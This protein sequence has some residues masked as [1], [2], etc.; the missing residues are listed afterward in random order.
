MAVNPLAHLDRTGDPEQQH[1][2]ARHQPFAYAR[3]LHWAEALPPPEAAVSAQATRDAEAVQAAAELAADRRAA[4]RAAEIA[5]EILAAEA[6]LP[7]RP[8]SPPPGGVAAG[9]LQYGEAALALSKT[10]PMWPASAAQAADWPRQAE[11]KN[12][13]EAS[14][15]AGNSLGRA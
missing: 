11:A 13:P 7:G 2:Y 1:A 3:H 12:C 15:A 6:Q 10:S 14:Y 5:A 8:H 9:P 4:E